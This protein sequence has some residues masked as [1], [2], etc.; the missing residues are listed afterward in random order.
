[1]AERSSWSFWPAAVASI[2]Q[3]L[4]A[5]RPYSRRCALVFFRRAAQAIGV[6][7]KS[8]QSRDGVAITHPG[9]LIN[10]PKG[11]LLRSGF[12]R[13]AARRM[14]ERSSWSL[15]LAA[16]ASI[17]QALLARRP[18]SRR[19]AL[20]FRRAAHRNGSAHKSSRSRNGVAITRPSR[21][22]HLPKNAMLRSGFILVHWR[23]RR[24]R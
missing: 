2:H 18:Y 8:S 23:R 17:H 3:A 5:R 21:L 15:R 20:V 13:R 19:C 22:L 16:I 24:F 14:A 4:L 7:D 6:A 11:G 12:I 10:T 9:C 1:M